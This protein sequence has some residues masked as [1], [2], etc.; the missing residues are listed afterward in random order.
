MNEREAVHTLARR[1]CQ[2]QFREW[3]RR[4]A[5]IQRSQSRRAGDYS[6]EAY[7]AF[8]RYLILQAILRSI[9]ALRPE[10]A[11]TVN[12]LVDAMTVAARDAQNNLTAEPRNAIAG[13]AIADERAKFFAYVRS[14]T[15]EP[16]SWP[17]PLPFRRTLT[18]AESDRFWI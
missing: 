5:E 15:A 18:K 9:E 11:D 10:S 4:Y 17:A 3:S 2:E 14:L 8:P 6:P 13:K 12:S 16:I 1:Y 7:D